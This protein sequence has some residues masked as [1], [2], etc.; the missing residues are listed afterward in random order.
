MERKQLREIKK[1]EFFRL[2]DSETAPVW[3]KTGGRI[4]REG[5]TKYEAEKVEDANHMNFFGG[6]KIVYVGFTY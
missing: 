2:V 4:K 1:H 6:D 5:K 3:V